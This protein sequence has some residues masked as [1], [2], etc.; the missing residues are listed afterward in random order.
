MVQDDQLGRISAAEAAAS[1]V[2]YSTIEGAP[3]MRF[4][5]CRP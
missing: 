5:D 2:T 3:G 4:F 1:G